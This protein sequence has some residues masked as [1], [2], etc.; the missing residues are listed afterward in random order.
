MDGMLA[1]MIDLVSRTNS[2]VC[3][4]TVDY[5]SAKSITVVRCILQLYCIHLLVASCTC[6]T[7]ALFSPA[8]FCLFASVCW[9][10]ATPFI[11]NLSCSSICWLV[12]SRPT[13]VSRYDRFLFH[14]Q[15]IGMLT[16]NVQG[17]GTQSGVS[18]LQFS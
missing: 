9:M 13:C 2:L 8:E 14:T 10:F 12:Y 3:S 17:A 7:A 5:S 18:C 6:Y 11:A 4:L 1:I 16:H 15:L